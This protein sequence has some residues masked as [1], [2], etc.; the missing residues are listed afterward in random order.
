MRLRM[1][2][3]KAPEPQAGSRIRRAL[4]CLTSLEEVSLSRESGSFS[5]K[6]LSMAF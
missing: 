3:G 6:R 4:R 2:M 1:P 5:L